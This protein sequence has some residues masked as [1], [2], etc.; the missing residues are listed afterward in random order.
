MWKQL[1]GLNSS[2]HHREQALYVW[3]AGQCLPIGDFQFGV[4][5]EE[6]HWNS[7]KS[8]WFI[9]FSGTPG[10][11]VLWATSQGKR[12]KN[13]IE[14]LIFPTLTPEFR[15]CRDS[16]LRSVCTMMKTKPRALCMLGKYTANLAAARFSVSVPFLVAKIKY[17]T[18]STFREKVWFEIAVQKVPVLDEAGLAAGMWSQ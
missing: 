8:S 4:L 7:E 18:R 5:F 3:P 11:C 15:G 6:D 1:M 9:F 12:P 17:L 16:P 2:H 13:D 14:P 10:I